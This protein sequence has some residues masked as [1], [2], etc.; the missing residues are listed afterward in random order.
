MPTFNS[1]MFCGKVVKVDE[2]GENKIA[3]LEEFNV[4]TQQYR[5]NGNYWR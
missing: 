4:M 3:K 1:S 2:N 5:L